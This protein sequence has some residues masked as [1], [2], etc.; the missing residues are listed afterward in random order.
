MGPLVRR[1]HRGHRLGTAVKIA[2][3]RALQ[4]AC[5]EAT[6]VKTQN[7]ETNAWMV[8]INVRLGFRPVGVVPEYLREI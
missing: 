6:E 3:L 5:P 4:Q 8:G 2:N 1:D 7:A